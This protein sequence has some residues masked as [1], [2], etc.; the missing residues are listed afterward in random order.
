MAFKTGSA[1]QLI[2]PT[3]AGVVVKTEYDNDAEQLKHLVEYKD[4]EGETQQRFFYADQ[5]AEMPTAKTG[6]AK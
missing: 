6:D 4:A 2:Q 3:I 5:L 1:V